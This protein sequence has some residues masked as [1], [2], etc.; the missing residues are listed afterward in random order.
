MS[1]LFS[2]YADKKGWRKPHQNREGREAR[3][4]ID[5]QRVMHN[6]ELTVGDLGLEDGDQVDCMLEQGLW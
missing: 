5:G 2:S 4:L 6:S 1:K 3:F